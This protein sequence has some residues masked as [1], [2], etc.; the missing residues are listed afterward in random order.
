MIISHDRLLWRNI[1]RFF[2]IHRLFTRVFYGHFDFT[3]LNN[4]GFRL[5]WISNRLLLLFLFL[6]AI[7]ESWSRNMARPL[8]RPVWPVRGDRS[9]QCS[10]LH[11]TRLAW[12]QSVVHG[13]PGAFPLIMWRIR[14][15]KTPHQYPFMLPCRICCTWRRWHPWHGSTHLGRIQCDNITLRLLD[16]LLGD[17]GRPWRGGDRGL[18]FSGR[19]FWMAFVYL[20]NNWSKMGF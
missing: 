18:F 8:V 11:W 14:H 17:T 19:S 4:I 2:N 20:F 16:S 7:L 9:D 15:R 10:L 13:H 6:D 12:P 5:L 1:S 3:D